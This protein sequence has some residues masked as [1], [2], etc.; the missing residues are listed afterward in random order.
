MSINTPILPNKL[1]SITLTTQDLQERLKSH[2]RC[3][4][5]EHESSG[6]SVFY[7]RLKIT[8]D[9]DYLDITEVRD[10][11]DQVLRPAI[12]ITKLEQRYGDR[13]LITDSKA[14]ITP[15]SIQEVWFYKDYLWH[16]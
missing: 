13:V 1:D 5:S 10:I 12:S 14:E 4:I 7:S 8:P 6:S 9:T 2:Y 16:Q 11:D 3:Q 15:E